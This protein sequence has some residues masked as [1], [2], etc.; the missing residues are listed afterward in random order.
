MVRLNSSRFM[1]YHS[2]NI[3]LCNFSDIEVTL[4]LNRVYVWVQDKLLVTFLKQQDEEDV[5]ALESVTSRAKLDRAELDAK[6][7]RAC[8]TVCFLPT[9]TAFTEVPSW[10]P[11]LSL[12]HHR[13]HRCPSLH[14]AH[15]VVCHTLPC[16]SQDYRHLSA[17]LWGFSLILAE[18]ESPQEDLRLQ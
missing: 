16:K 15:I 14:N 17:A 4:L 6:S 8:L 7:G 1:S 13:R 9:I 10:V 11:S 3:K 12:S 5:I 18:P 2:A